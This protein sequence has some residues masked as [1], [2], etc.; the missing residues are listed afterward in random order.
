MRPR[1]QC[2]R[3]IDRPAASKN[4]PVKDQDPQRPGVSHRA[5][6][7]MTRSIRT[8][9]LM[10]S[11]SAIGATLLLAGIIL[12]VLFERHLEINERWELEAQWARLAD[13]VRTHSS[14]PIAIE[15][16]ANDPRFE[17]PDSGLYWQISRQGKSVLRS[18]S[19]V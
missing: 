4:R 19:L 15:A 3:G 5:R 8:R 11:G 2:D 7:M 6:A 17:R 1:Q 10:S 14:K 18:A 13:Q 16:A 9:L 12:V